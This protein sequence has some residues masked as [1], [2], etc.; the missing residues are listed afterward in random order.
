V[1]EPADVQKVFVLK[2]SPPLLH[3]DVNKYAAGNASGALL[4]RLSTWK[5]FLTGSW[6]IFQ[7]KR[8][9]VKFSLSALPNCSIMTFNPI[10]SSLMNYG[11]Q[12]N[13]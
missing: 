1:R 11:P 3:L 8:V 10:A 5:I 12:E 13:F 4:D 6:Y 2:F 7:Q 9:S